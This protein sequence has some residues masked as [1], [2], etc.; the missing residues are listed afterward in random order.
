MVKVVD[1]VVDQCPVVIDS[2]W[3]Q[4]FWVC[5]HSTCEKKNIVCRWCVYAVYYVYARNCDVFVFD[6]VDFIC[7]YVLCVL[8]LVVK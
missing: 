3:V 6:D 4:E 2:V 8:M 1:Y 7:G 5:V